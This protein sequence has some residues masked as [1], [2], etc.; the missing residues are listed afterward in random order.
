[1]KYLIISDLHL[2]KPNKIPEIIINLAKEMKGIICAGDLTSK[3][4]LEKLK[5]INKNL[6]VVKGNCD[7]LD[8]PEYLEFKIENKKIGVIHS[9]Q[10]GRGNFEKIEEFA[11]S[12]KLDVLIFGHTHQPLM[13]KKGNLLLINPGT[14]TGA[15]SGDGTKTEKTWVILEIGKEINAKINRL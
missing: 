5:E 11:N 6:I 7:Y 9:N 13:E 3:T 10:F 12:K 8:L 15:V 1:M 2:S 4:V 14:L